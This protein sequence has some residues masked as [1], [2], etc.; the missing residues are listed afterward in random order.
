MMKNIKVR[1]SFVTCRSMGAESNNEGR[2][3]RRHRAAGNHG[4][5]TGM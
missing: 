3:Y 1:T 2:Q 5:G 4:Q